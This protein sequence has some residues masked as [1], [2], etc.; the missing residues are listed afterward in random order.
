MR[1]PH[2]TV[3]R[4]VAFGLGL[5]ALAWAIDV[6]ATKVDDRVG[7]GE[8]PQDLG[9]FLRAAGA[10]LHGHSPYAFRA[11]QTY[12][13]PPLVAFLAAPLRPF[14]V[15]T[16][17]TLSILVSLAAIAGA[18]WLL[19][20]RDWRCY[21][22]VPLYPMTRSAVGLGTVGPLLLLATAAAWRWR[23]RLLEPAVAVGRAAQTASRAGRRRAAAGAG[24]GL[25]RVADRLDPLLPAAARPD[26]AHAA[27]SV[28]NLGRA[29][30]V[31][32]AR[33]DGL[34]GRG[35]TQARARARGHGAPDRRLGPPWSGRGGDATDP[36]GPGRAARRRRRG[37]GGSRSVAS[38]SDE[39]RHDPARPRRGRH[40]RRAARV[41][42]ERRSR[43]RH[44]D[45]QP[46]A[47]RDHRDPR[48]VRARRMPSSDPR[49]GRRHAAGAVGDADGP[50]RGGR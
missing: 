13:Y 26:R 23:V 36:V 12:A 49:A 10:V 46:L 8:P 6:Y 18:L 7:V 16:A 1:L 37:H 35:R 39:A 9:V 30:R 22:L 14:G 34:A 15:G 28:A 31:L 42:P 5:L 27:A 50:A 45:R 38:R 11:D 41:P 29:V 4:L 20:V 24:G 43:L 33:R 17:M 2:R 25:R 3:A 21:C 32:A 47:G 40:R 19:G 48:G 44:R